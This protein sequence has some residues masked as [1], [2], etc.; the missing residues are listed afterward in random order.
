MQK[1]FSFIGRHAIAV[2][3]IIALITGFFG[4]QAMGIVLNADFG[5]LLPWGERTAYYQGGVDGQIANLGSE[6]ASGHV[7]PIP[8]IPE[9]PEE[10]ESKH[11]KVDF[12]SLPEV[13][14]EYRN[15]K[16]TEEDYK[17]RAEHLVYVES[18]ELYNEYYLNLIEE[19]FARI[20][21][22]RD[23]GE[24]S[25]VLDF[26]TLAKK[27]TRIST[28]PMNPDTDRNWTAEEAE[29][30]A[31]RIDE[32]PIIK[33]FLVNGDGNGMLF[34]FP[35]SSTS[36]SALDEFEAL[37][38]PLK[39][40]GLT[41]YVNGGPA[42]NNKV[43]EYLQ[44]DLAT[45]MVLCI[46]AIMV[47]FYFSFR[48]KRSVLIPSSLSLIALIWT[49]GTMKM[50]GI[51]ITLLNIVT[52]CMVITLGS[53]YSIHVLSE[54][55]SHYHSGDGLTPAES[56][57]KIM[58][59]IFL[60]CLTTIVGFLC[61]CISETQ[62]LREFGI[63]VSMGI[64]YCAFLAAFYLPAIL[65]ITP[66]PKK[67]AVKSFENGLMTRLVGF[68]ST[69]ITRYWKILIVVFFILFAV[70]FMVKDLIPVDSNYMSYFPKNDVFGQESKAFAKAM[71]GTNPYEIHIKAPEGS[72]NFFLDKDN[73]EKVRTYEESLLASPDILQCISFTNYLSFANYEMNDVYGIPETSGLINLLS[74]M[75]L[76]LANQGN[77]ELSQIISSDFNEMTIVVQ[78]WDA[79]EEDL[80][81]TSSIGRTYS[82]IVQN[83]AMLPEGTSVTIV[84]DPLVNVVFANRLLSD[85]AKSTFL[86]VLMV[87]IIT[88][89]TFLSITRGFLTIIP[90]F[91]GVMINYVF[92]YIF[93]IPFDMVTVSF[94]SIAIGCG[95]DDAIHFVLR[96]KKKYKSGMNYIDC[97]KETILETGRPIILT[98]VSI[99]FGMMMLSF[100]SY[101][102]IRYFGLLMS[103]SLFGCMVST[104]FFLPS[105]AILIYGIK[106]RLFGRKSLNDNK[107]ELKEN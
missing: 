26:F 71:G 75:V 72:K 40:A 61:L 10:V 35:T 88:A 16:A 50:M 18:E 94:S 42:I 89:I 21:A 15:F 98:T 47:V 82:L 28:V 83:L 9:R 68:L 27:G 80:M 79:V 57:S 106:D 12:S 66:Q 13:G 41:V 69:F 31:K 37:L 74:R 24:P 29:I 36:Q 107:K 87:F 43:M 93:N 101:M 64:F 8:V 48:S 3:V 103:I 11:D 81:T 58:G 55:Y 1:F 53:A 63:S 84:G 67:K 34:K 30:L 91:S 39:D 45:L 51:A 49:F 54:Y 7:D 17:Y 92:M 44:K 6:K 5:S 76:M 14:N 62:G 104:L 2:L 95:V 46:V 102:P 90:V 33:Y 99:V 97:I 60:A 23:I 22:R 105:F 73:L 25:S 96:F 32:D 86:S 4:Y 85:Q 77:T 100:A 78:H 20:S 38:Q 52:P 19:T 70:F 65:S 59:T 56:T